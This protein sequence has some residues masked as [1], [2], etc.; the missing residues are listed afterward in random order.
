MHD[1]RVPAPRRPEH[2]RHDRRHGR[3]T[4][5]DQLVP[6][7]GRVDE[8][9]Q[10]VEDRR[11][12][13]LL[14]DRAHEA[15]GRVEALGEA[16]AHARLRHAAGH[17]FG[18][19]LDGHAQRLEHV[20][21]A[22]RRRRGA[23]AVLAHRHAAPRGDERGQRR[24][25]DARQPV[26]PGPDQVDRRPGLRL[27]PAGRARPRRAWRGPDPVTSSAVSPLACSRA[28]K[29]PTCAGV[30]SP[31]RTISSVSSASVARERLPARSGGPGPRAR[32]VP[33][34]VP[35]E[36]APGD[37][38]ELHLGGALDDGELLGVAVPLLGRDGPPCSRP[39]RAAGRRATRPARPARWRGTW[40]WTGTGRT[41]W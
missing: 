28:R 34:Q 21:R 12:A 5:T 3:I 6:R 2:A 7:P 17:A 33:P 13:Q 10:E 25:V 24:H 11:H 31:A 26:A 20:R 4:D 38:A 1:Q 19:D 36:H 30:A 40:P 39:R 29:A 22:H 8:R 23:V 41:P 32:S 9:S 18:P 15:H 14:A 16:E 37:Q 27:R 35:V